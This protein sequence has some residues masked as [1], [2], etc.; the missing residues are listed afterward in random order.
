MFEED[1]GTI[2]TVVRAASES[3]RRTFFYFIFV[4]YICFIK[5]L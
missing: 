2:H 5:I 1:F 4:K 3:V